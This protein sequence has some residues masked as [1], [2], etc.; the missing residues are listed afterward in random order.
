MSNMDDGEIFKNEFIL[1]DNYLMTFIIVLSLFINSLIRDQMFTSSLFSLRTSSWLPRSASRSCLQIRF[2]F[3]NP[4]PNSFHLH[5]S[6]IFLSSPYIRLLTLISCYSIKTTFLCD[7][8]SDFLNFNTYN[9]SYPFRLS[10][11]GLTMLCAHMSDIFH[12]HSGD[13]HTERKLER[14]I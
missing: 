13:G 6:H 4:P 14:A 5:H 9:N 2:S 7:H 12:F 3:L 8:I 10:K 1:N 11:S